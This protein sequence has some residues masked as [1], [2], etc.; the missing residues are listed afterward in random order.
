MLLSLHCVTERKVRRDG[1]PMRMLK[2]LVLDGDRVSDGVLFREQGL[3]LGVYS[4]NLPNSFLSA[5]RQLG[6][7]GLTFQDIN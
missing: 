1:T 7:S 5:V 2:K 3:S 4:T 6:L